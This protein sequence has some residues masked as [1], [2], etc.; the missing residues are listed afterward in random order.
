MV[1]FISALSVYSF[2]T[3]VATGERSTPSS[4]FTTATWS[5]VSPSVP[6]GG[7]EPTRSSPYS[8]MHQTPSWRRTGWFDL[9]ASTEY[10][11]WVA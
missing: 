4:S 2:V 8:P 7:A 10:S 1:S 6:S 5:G 11:L 3:V 9:A